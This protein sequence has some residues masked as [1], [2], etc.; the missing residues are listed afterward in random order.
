LIFF[1]LDLIS[2][3]RL[4]ALLS[5]SQSKEKDAVP[6]SEVTEPPQSSPNNRFKFKTGTISFGS[7]LK[8]WLRKFL[9]FEN[10]ALSTVGEKA[11]P[12]ASEQVWFVVV[13]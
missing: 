12:V 5:A 4:L 11:L 1:S 10:A 9:K 8:S 2:L 3:G 7:H 6:L 13:E